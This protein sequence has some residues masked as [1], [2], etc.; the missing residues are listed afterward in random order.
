MR[1]LSL[2]SLA[3]LGEQGTVVS[4]V[5]LIGVPWVTGSIPVAEISASKM[6]KSEPPFG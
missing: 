6:L 1:E 3:Q 4:F 2:L 5:I